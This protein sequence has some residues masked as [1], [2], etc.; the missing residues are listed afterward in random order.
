M[1]DK[2]HPESEHNESG[3][4]MVDAPSDTLVDIDS[5]LGDHLAAATVSAA[6]KAQIPVESGDLPDADKGDFDLWAEIDGGNPHVTMTTEQTKRQKINPDHPA[7]LA[8]KVG[9]RELDEILDLRG[10]SDIDDKQAQSLSDI[11]KRLVNLARNLSAVYQD[12]Y[13]DDLDKEGDWH[14]TVMHNDTALGP[15]KVKPANMNDPIAGLRVKFG[16]GG[17]VQIPLWNTGLWV[18]LRAPTLRALLD[19]DQ[20]LRMEKMNLGRSSNGMV[21]SASEVYTVETYMKFAME[22]VVAVNYV[23]ETGDATNE[24]LAVIRTRDYQQVMWGMALAMYPDGYPLRQPCIA[25]VDTCKHVDELLLN[26]A[27]INYVDRSKISNNQALKMASRNTKRDIKWL[28]E[29]QSEFALA[30]KHIN[31]GKGLVAVLG[32]CSVMEQVD[33]GHLWVDG[34]AKSTNEAFGARLSEMDRV[35]HIMRQGALTNLRQYSHWIVRFEDSS[36][37]D[38]APVIYDDMVNKD[39]ILELLSEDPEVSTMLTKEMVDWFRRGSITYNALV[40]T[41]CPACQG[42]S[43]DH[44]HPYLT[45]IDIGYIFFTLA[46]QKINRVEKGME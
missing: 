12:V 11:D 3:M 2:E 26:F 7:I 40:K 38:D 44:T 33:S 18:T 5:P 45:P 8:F 43:T 13:F 36:G 29:Y 9:A 22:H 37:N 30:T 39:R 35:R 24:L 25:D 34:I 28:T 14:N 20:K 31:L 42:K 46:G 1:T 10:L 17:M 27:R 15:G 23:F 4:E 6:A 21:Y 19:F 41:P 16:Q 32:S